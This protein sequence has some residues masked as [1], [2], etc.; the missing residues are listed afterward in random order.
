MQETSTQEQPTEEV[1][2]TVTDGDKETETSYLDGKY[3]SVSALED[4][5]RELNKTFSQK[6]GT[7]QGSPEEYAYNEG[8]NAIP[9]LEEWGRE[10][11]LN[12][13]G[14]NGLVELQN[15][16]S[17]R[18]DEEYQNQ[19][20][21]EIESLGDNAKERIANITDFLSANKIEG[22]DPTTAAGF[23]S[24][25]KL[26]AMTKTPAP[27]TAP[28][29]QTVDLDAIKQMRFAKDE[30]GNRKM[31]SDPEYRARVL[32]LEAQLKGA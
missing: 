18:A 11:Q 23:E 5:Y 26:I 15:T 19:I 10:N 29:A 28:T 12:N 2:A 24:L 17:Q 7:F 31:S 22:I 13:D 27:Q 4:G 32:K 16:L 9:E 14:L 8:L 3:K 25:E 20:K 30:Y 21:T 1:V 6:L